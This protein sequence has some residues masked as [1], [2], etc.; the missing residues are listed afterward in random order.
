MKIYNVGLAFPLILLASATVADE[1]IS[2]I[3]KIMKM[4]ADP[5]QAYLEITD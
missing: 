5:I 3:M 2:P 1:P 4:G